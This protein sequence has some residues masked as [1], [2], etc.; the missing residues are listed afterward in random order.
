MLLKRSCDGN[1][2]VLAARTAHTD[3]KLA[4]AL[5]IVKRYREIEQIESAL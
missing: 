2:A 4:F 1:A 5:F 3:N